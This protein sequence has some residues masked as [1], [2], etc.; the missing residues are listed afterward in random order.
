MIIRLGKGY[1]VWDWRRASHKG[2]LLFWSPNGTPWHEGAVRLIGKKKCC[3][4]CEG[5]KG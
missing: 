2:W 4:F 1:L 5:I 3:I